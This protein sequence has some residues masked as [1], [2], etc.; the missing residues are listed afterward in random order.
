MSRGFYNDE[1][2]SAPF[3][4][5]FAKKSTT[6][7]TKTRRVRIQNRGVKAGDARLIWP[8]ASLA[9]SLI[10]ARSYSAEFMTFLTV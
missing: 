3:E 9:D 7:F 6:F 8:L 1:I 2:W 4:F 10:H 5:N